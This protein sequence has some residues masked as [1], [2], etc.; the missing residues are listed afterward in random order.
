MFSA[1]L[2]ENPKL[3]YLTIIPQSGRWHFSWNFPAHK[4]KFLG[5]AWRARRR[6]AQRVVPSWS[7]AAA[8]KNNSTLFD[9]HGLAT[10]IKNQFVKHDKI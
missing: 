2:K 10:S 1:L 3:Y 4:S 7:S 9:Y 6:A 5:T 8:V